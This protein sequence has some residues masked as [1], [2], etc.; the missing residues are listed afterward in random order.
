MNTPSKSKATTPDGFPVYVQSQVGSA[1]DPGQ[2]MRLITDDLYRDGGA[3]SPGPSTYSFT[4]DGLAFT[5]TVE[6]GL[7]L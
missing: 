1:G 2:A 5:V 4:Y 6:S 3:A 7:K